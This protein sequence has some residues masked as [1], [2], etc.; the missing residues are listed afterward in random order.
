KVGY[1]FQHAALFDSMTVLQNLALAIHDEDRPRPLGRVRPEAEA[2][3]RRVN[4]DPDVLDQYPAE[5]SGGMRKRVGVARA[6]AS[7][8][9]YVLY[10]E[11]TTGLDP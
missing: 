7:R 6:I 9:R 2:L 10:D 5:L 4:L 11:P 1:V 3:L 8:P